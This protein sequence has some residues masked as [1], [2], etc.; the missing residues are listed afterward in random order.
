MPGSIRVGRFGRTDIGVHITFLP[1]LAGAAWLGANQYGGVNGAIFG[2]MAVLLLFVCVLIHEIAHASYA[3]TCGVDV[4]TIVL[5][6][7]C[8]DGDA[9]GNAYPRSPQ[10]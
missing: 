4:T 9:L 7:I 2:L 10:G 3:R 8:G 1:M 5:L 6:P